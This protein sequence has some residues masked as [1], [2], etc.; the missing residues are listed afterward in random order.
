M[1]DIRQTNAFYI[2]FMRECP[3]SIGKRCGAYRC[4]DVYEIFRLII[5]HRAGQRFN[6]D[7]CLSFRS[8]VNA[9]AE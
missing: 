4:N 6:C 3:Y 8:T 1:R 5:G 7:F 9:S 2:L